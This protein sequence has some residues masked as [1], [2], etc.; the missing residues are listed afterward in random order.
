METGE[1]SILRGGFL[2]DG[3]G[4]GV[5]ALEDFF[6]GGAQAAG[7][8]A[9]CPIAPIEVVVI[10]LKLR[11]RAGDGI[12]PAAEADHD[13]RML[14]EI[15]LQRVAV[16]L[17]E[18]VDLVLAAGKDIAVDAAVRMDQVK[19][20]GDAVVFKR[21]ERLGAIGDEI[22]GLEKL[23]RPLKKRLG[24]SSHWRRKCGPPSRAA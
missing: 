23:Q 10:R 4:D 19:G 22:R 9:V 13:D 6:G 20:P 5:D 21:F 18:Q 7:F 24:A 11:Q 3:V 15:S 16:P 2:L 8:R 1:T 14:A 17:G 12:I